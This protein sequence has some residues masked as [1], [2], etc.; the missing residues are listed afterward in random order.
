MDKYLV[1]HQRQK[2]AK[3]NPSKTT[4]KIVM[5]DSLENAYVAARKLFDPID[6]HDIRVTKVSDKS[7]LI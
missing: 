5:A 1:T 3:H 2:K 4:K 7:T 6:I